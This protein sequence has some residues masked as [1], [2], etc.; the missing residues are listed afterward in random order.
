MLKLKQQ[1]IKLVNELSNEDTTLSKKI[2]AVQNRIN[3][4]T[5]AMHKIL[6]DELT[7][8][9]KWIFILNKIIQIQSLLDI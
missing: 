5:K 8:V 4:Q 7:P 6:D 2:S 9:F 1:T 3:D